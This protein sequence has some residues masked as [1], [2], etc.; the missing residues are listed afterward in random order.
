MGAMAAA[1]LPV[2][3]WELM[4][5][6]WRIKFAAWTV[7]NNLRALFRPLVLDGQSGFLYRYVRNFELHEYGE[8]ALFLSILT[9]LF[10]AAAMAAIM[11]RSIEGREAR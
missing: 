4:V 11:N 1:I 8:A 10:L 2:F 5:T 3:F 6:W 9:G 7:T